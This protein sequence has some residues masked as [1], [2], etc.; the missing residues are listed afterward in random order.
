[1]HRTESF[2]NTV[3]MRNIIAASCAALFFA[4]L[5]LINKLAFVEQKALVG[6]LALLTLALILEAKTK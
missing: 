5:A 4:D 3:Q 1:M 2:L 6:V